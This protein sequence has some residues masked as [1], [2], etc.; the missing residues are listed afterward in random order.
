MDKKSVYIETSVISYLAARR[1][2]NLVAVAWQEVSWEFWEAHRSS[3]DLY[4]SELVV[5]EASAGQAEAAERR[6]ALLRGI[7]E[8]AATD[9]ARKLSASI[10]AQGALPANAEFDALHIAIAAVHSVDLILTW[11]CR[12]LDNPTTKPLVRRVCAE[13]GYVCPEICTPLELVEARADEE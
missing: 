8:L 11:N 10:L 6:L 1:S 3:Y 13:C 4:T 12:H 7:P 9:S 2:R 5:A